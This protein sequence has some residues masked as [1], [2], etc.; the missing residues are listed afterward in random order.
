M[1]DTDSQTAT[2]KPAFLDHSKPLAPLTN[3]DLLGQTGNKVKRFD[4][5]MRLFH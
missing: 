4:S 1:Q 2:G 3:S 5:K